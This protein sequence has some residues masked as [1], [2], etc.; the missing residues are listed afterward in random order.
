[1]P[2]YEKFF[3]HPGQYA[4]WNTKARFAV[5]AAGRRSGKTKLAIRKL[6]MEAARYTTTDHGRF[7]YGAPTRDQ[8]KRIAW[9]QIKDG[10]PPNLIRSIS[11]TELTVT[12]WNGADVQVVGFDK[13]MR[14]EGDAIDGA[15]LDEFADMK[16]E[17]WTQTLRLSLGTRGREGWCWFIGKPRGRNHFYDIYRRAQR[18]A[19]GRWAAF[20]W[21]SEEI[22]TEQEIAAL[23]DDLQLDPP[24]VRPRGPSELRQ[25][26]RP[27]LLLLSRGRPRL[28]SAE[29]PAPQAPRFRLRLQRRTWLSGRQ[30]AAGHDGSARLA[31]HSGRQ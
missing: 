25:L 27:R 10:F 3:H 5:T 11:E 19:S 26:R 14:A 6:C 16:E 20:H 28:V 22:L 9:R 4:L 30:S 15:V 31:R 17:A 18:D 1:M 21:S 12:L 29:L 13:P 2:K 8:A 23:I 7:I 24:V